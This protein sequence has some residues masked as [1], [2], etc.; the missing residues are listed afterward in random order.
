MSNVID[1]SDLASEVGAVLTMYAQNVT[2]ETSQW[3]EKTA[4]DTA[5]DLKKSS[6]KKSGKYAQGWSATK[7]NGRWVVHNKKRPGLAHLTEN[8]HPIVRG[9]VVV[10]HAGANHH[11]KNAE[12]RAQEKIQ[13]LAKQLKKVGV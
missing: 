9:G 5:K 3:M 12:Q 11:I 6:P 10:G 4:R 13:D 8:G 1:L 2:N 7:K